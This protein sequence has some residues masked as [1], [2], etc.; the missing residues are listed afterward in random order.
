MEK[1]PSSNQLHIFFD[2][3]PDTFKQW[4][5][6]SILSL[7]GPIEIVDPNTG[8]ILQ[9]PPGKISLSY[10]KNEMTGQVELVIDYG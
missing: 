4:T 3:G 9:I 6:E 8:N 7:L 10:H 5:P 1:D 2:L